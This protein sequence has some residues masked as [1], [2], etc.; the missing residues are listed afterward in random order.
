MI[1]IASVGASL[2]TDK[3]LGPRTALLSNSSFNATSSGPR[4]DK[5]R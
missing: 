3:V 2:S 5:L 4:S 1:F